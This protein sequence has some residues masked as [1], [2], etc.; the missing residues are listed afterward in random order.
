MHRL[1]Q[2]E[3]LKGFRPK[4]RRILISDEIGTPR[5]YDP[6][7]LFRPQVCCAYAPGYSRDG[8]LAIV[9]L[10]LP[11]S[12]GKHGGNGTYV[13][14]RNEGDWVVLTRVFVHYRSDRTTRRSRRQLLAEQ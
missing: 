8:Q 9:R 7:R 2:K 12:G 5:K 3:P 6:L 1:G 10:T 11:W 14:T 4:D 13:L